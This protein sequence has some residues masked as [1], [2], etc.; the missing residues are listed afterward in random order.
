[1]FMLMLRFGIEVE[2][3]ANLTMGVIDVKRRT[4]LVEDG[5]GGKTG[6]SM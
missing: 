2:E 6:S 1:M 4:I 3:V 5:K